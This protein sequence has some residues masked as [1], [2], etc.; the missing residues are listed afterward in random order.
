[1]EINQEPRQSEAIKIIVKDKG[2]VVGWAFL[3]FIKN[4][5]HEEPYALL[6]NVYVEQEFR[7]HGVGSRLVEA[8]V[9]VAR[10]KGCYKIIG[11]TRHEKEAVHKF[12]ER[13]G[14][15]DHGLEFRL[16]LKDSAIL[17]RD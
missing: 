7:K 3:Y 8:A 9:A 14:F 5:R 6:E 13:F 10:A 12:Y 15:R 4:D 2:Q 1:M 17:Q 11:T 16:D